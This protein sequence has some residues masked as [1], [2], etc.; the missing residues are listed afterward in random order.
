MGKSLHKEQAG[1]VVVRIGVYYDVVKMID[2]GTDSLSRVLAKT[3]GSPVLYCSSI[4][5][6]EESRQIGCKR[7]P[8]A[9]V[10]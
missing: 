8:I 9:F 7:V 10:T 6:V 5:F 3:V 4:D 1:I 2:V